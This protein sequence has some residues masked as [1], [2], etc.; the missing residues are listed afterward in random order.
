MQIDPVCPQKCT[1]HGVPKLSF[2]QKKIVAT[3]QTIKEMDK[4]VNVHVK[5][6]NAHLCL[7]T[8]PRQIMRQ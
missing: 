6:S 2:V 7:Q 1:L 3:L 5:L 4:K 8:A